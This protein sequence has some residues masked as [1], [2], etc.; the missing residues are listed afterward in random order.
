MNANVTTITAAAVLVPGDAVIIGGDL[1][2]V[3][4]VVTGTDGTHVV[5]D[6]GFGISHRRTYPA[7][8][9]VQLAG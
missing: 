6:M 9:T 5:F 2:Y 4:H 8:G 1:G 3:T 7:G